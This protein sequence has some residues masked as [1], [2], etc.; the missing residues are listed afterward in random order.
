MNL[1]KSNILIFFFALL[2]CF[3]TAFNIEDTKLGNVIP[4]NTTI[5][6]RTAP[7]F[8]VQIDDSPINRWR[9]IIQHF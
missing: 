7:K 3:T 2:L 8:K 4:H 1:V 5:P 9:P 6:S